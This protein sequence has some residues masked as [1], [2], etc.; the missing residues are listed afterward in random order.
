MAPHLYWQDLQ[1]AGTYDLAPTEGF[2]T[3]YPVSLPDGREILLPIRELP[4]NG[5]AVASLIINQASFAV[6]DAIGDSVTELVRAVDPE[7][8]VG[9]PTLGLTL[10]ASVARRLHQDRLVALGTSRKFWY[11]DELSH[12]LTSITTPGA[13]KHVFIDPRM[14]PLL[15]GRR[16]V[17]VD[18]VISSGTSISA[19]LE[20]MSNCGITVIG[21]ACAMLQS[22][23]WQE[24]L[25]K[26]LADGQFSVIAPLATPFLQRGAN[27]NWYPCAE[28][29]AP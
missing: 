12:P 1:P 3:S 16:V 13:G 4:T 26:Y 27:G 10:A 5:M 29:P 2:T 8:I 20:L 14:L 28:C 19:V 22:N 23:V 25:E 7:V 17:I 21:V 11:D 24:S 6:Q 18:D 15:R 9:V